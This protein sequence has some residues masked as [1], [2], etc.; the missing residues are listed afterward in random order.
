MDKASV[1]GILMLAA[2]MGP[3]GNIERGYTPKSERN[4]RLRN[5]TK[6]GRARKAKN[7]VARA[8]RLRNRG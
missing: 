6:A 5:K 8:S 1:A 2:L 3:S 4:S 7:A